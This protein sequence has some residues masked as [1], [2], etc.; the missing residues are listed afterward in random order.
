MLHY[1]KQMLEIDE[2]LENKDYASIIDD[3]MILTEFYGDSCE[4]N[5]G[6][7]HKDLYVFIYSNV[8][9]GLVDFGVRY[10]TDMGETDTALMLLDELYSREYISS[11]SKASQVMLG[12]KLALQ[13]IEVDSAADPKRI[14][15]DYTKANK[16]YK[17]LEKA[18]LQKWKDL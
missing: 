9:S 7:Q 18:Y 8:N 6:I 15:L 16:W 1:Q 2:M 13:D 5:F 12:N 17:Y 4:N 3:Y 14:V 10:Y 11:W